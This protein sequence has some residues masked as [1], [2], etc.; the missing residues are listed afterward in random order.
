MMRLQQ[1]GGWIDPLPRLIILGA[2]QGFLDMGFQIVATDG[3]ADHFE[4][5]GVP[6]AGAWDDRMNTDSEAYGGSGM[7]TLGRAYAAPMPS[8]R[9]FAA[10]GRLG[11]EM[12]FR[13]PIAGGAELAAED[14]RMAARCLGRA[15]G[16]ID[17]EDVLDEILQSSKS[18]IGNNVSP[19]M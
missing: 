12:C 5:H 16:R 17:V 19:L 14:L 10:R 13:R 6:V 8:I 15:V 7:G 3:T 4:A 1:Q 2:A 9:R 11:P 18:M